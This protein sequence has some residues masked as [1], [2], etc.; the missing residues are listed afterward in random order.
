MTAI[1]DVNESR[2]DL[3]RRAFILEW[4]TLGWLFIEATAG[5]WA[6]L[7]AH[8][9]SLLAFGLDSV[10]E[11]ISAGVLIWRLTVELRHGQTFSEDAERKA[12]RIA[13]ALLLALAAY[14]VLSAA[15]GL[16]RHQG[17]KFS[18]LGLAVTAATIPV[19][20]LLA[21]RKIAIAEQIGSRALRADA[22][23]S[24][25]CGW[26]S[27]VIVV[28]LLAQLAIGAWWIDSVTSLAVVY[29]LVKEAREAW[30]G[31]ECGCASSWP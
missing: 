6:A 9:L 26:L 22:M 11:A 31:E 21:R 16:W 29:F 20:Y 25:T 5:L 18:A 13:G 12:S 7:E 27:F 24:I 1:P 4:L 2:S 15:W 23:E 30:A 14:V 8:S 10:I 19:M 3:I 28:G 17:E